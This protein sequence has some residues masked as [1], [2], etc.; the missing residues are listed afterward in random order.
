VGT[1]F[2]VAL[3]LFVGS[4]ALVAVSVTACLTA[5]VV[6]AIYSPLVIVP[7]A[8]ANDQVTAVF[9]VPAAVA[10]NC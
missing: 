9:A 3:A 1:R 5:I 10:V 4:A 6:G 8:G 7:I 2:I